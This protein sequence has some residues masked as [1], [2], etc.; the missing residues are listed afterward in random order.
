MLT[1]ATMMMRTSRETQSVFSSLWIAHFVAK[2]CRTFSSIRSTFVSTS[3]RV[4]VGR[5]RALFADLSS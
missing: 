5:Q 3:G 1:M 4:V 2:R